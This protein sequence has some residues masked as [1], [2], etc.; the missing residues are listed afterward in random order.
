LQTNS[1]PAK[2][3]IYDSVTIFFHWA[4]ML[5]V[6]AMFLLVLCPGVVKGSI[7]LHRSLGITILV[8]V[9]LRIAWRLFFG[10][11]T[12]TSAAEPLLLRIGAKGAHAALYAL[13]IITPLL[14]WLY[15]DAKAVDFNL[16][17]TNVDLPMLL[18]YD[19]GLA[20]TLYGWKQVA[21][22]SLLALVC[23]HFVAAVA[24]HSMLRKDGVLRSMLPRR[25][26]A[27]LAA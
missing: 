16:F 2:D 13:L 1:R 21:A 6:L 23:A 12:Q 8:I 15:Q 18:Y 9:P 26:R 10:R 17:G 27:R 19:R 25:M 20:M 5:L 3:D 7:A 22:Y 14:G 11:K 24:Y 4:T